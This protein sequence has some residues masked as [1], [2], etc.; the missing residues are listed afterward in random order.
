MFNDT[1]LSK[2]RYHSRSIV[3]KTLNDVCSF[4][5]VG[6][7]LLNLFFLY[8]EEKML[9]VCYVL[10]TSLEIVRYNFEVPLLFTDFKE[11]LIYTVILL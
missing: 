2:L 4:S 3:I 5:E 10:R 8:L 7:C 11:S 6:C 1:C 9:L